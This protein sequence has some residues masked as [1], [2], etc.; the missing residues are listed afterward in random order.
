MCHRHCE[1][2]T[3][4]D[5]DRSQLDSVVVSLFVN[6]ET[7]MLSSL[8]PPFLIFSSGKANWPRVRPAHLRR[9]WSPATVTN[10]KS[11]PLVITRLIMHRCITSDDYEVQGLWPWVTSL[12]KELRTKRNIKSGL[13]QLW[14]ICFIHVF[15]SPGKHQELRHSLAD[16]SRLHRKISTYLPKS[17]LCLCLGF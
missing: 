6:W 7:P 14:L 16:S 8:S 11:G 12:C 3:G 9:L 1:G 2:W 13:F 5:L 15:F 4:G 10:V 17:K